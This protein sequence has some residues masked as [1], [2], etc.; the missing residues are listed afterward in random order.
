[1]RNWRLL[2]RS[3]GQAPIPQAGVFPER[4]SLFS[5]LTPF[6][7]PGKLPSGAV[8]TVQGRSPGVGTHGRRTL[9]AGPRLDMGQHELLAEP[10]PSDCRAV[11]LDVLARE[12][13]QQPPALSN[14][15]EQPAA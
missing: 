7:R 14:E 6:S 13:R 8:G 12:V 2:T 5:A 4:R 15:L 9:N 11:A 1:M 3:A 10:E